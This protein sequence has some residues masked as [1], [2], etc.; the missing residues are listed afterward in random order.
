M[1]EGFSFPG[2]F[3]DRQGRQEII[4]RISPSTRRQPPGVMGYEIKTVI[5]GVSFTGYDFDDLEP[6][7]PGQAIAAGLPLSR[8]SGELAD[9]VLAGD[10]P[11]T[12]E[13]DG[14]RDSAVLKFALTLL[15]ADRGPE[16]IQP[17]P[18]NLRLSV[19]VA[20]QRFEVTDDWFEDGV[21]QLDQA[22]RAVGAKLVCCVTCL[23]SDYSPAGHGL[24]GMQCHR[25]AKAQYLAVKTKLDY[26]SV[27]V[28]EDVM[29]TYLCPDGSQ[30]PA[31]AADNRAVSHHA[32]HHAVSA[33]T[34]HHGSRATFPTLL[35]AGA[36]SGRRL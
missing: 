8:L 5:R 14:R 3:L 4:W 24:T 20:G 6:E 29:E 32:P 9:G 16:R 10:L 26:W 34:G 25:G 17:S 33:L 21:L 13:V 18:K 35:S 2:T 19:V 28:T 22:V 7:E 11:C 36:S 27:P 30:A 23:Y 31:T 15:S 12:I 1:N